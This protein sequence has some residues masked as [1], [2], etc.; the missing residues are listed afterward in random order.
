[1]RTIENLKGA[2]R[3]FWERCAHSDYL[4]AAGVVD[5][6]LRRQMLM[7]EGSREI[8][9]CGDVCWEWAGLSSVGA[10]FLATVANPFGGESRADT[11]DAERAFN[12]ARAYARRFGETWPPDQ[13]FGSS[14]FNVW[15][16]DYLRD[17]G[18][19]VTCENG[20]HKA[21]WPGEV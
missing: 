1:M 9:C 4:D 13:G 10:R 20:R 5:T 17:L 11:V 12:L 21:V 7:A 2:V 8:N 14:D 18:F 19:A 6:A 16:A 15:A 3:L